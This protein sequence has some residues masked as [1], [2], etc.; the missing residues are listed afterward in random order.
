[1]EPNDEDS[2][3]GDDEGS[4]LHYGSVSSSIY[5]FRMENGRTYHAV[6]NFNLWKEWS[7]DIFV[8]STRTEKEQDRMDLVYHAILRLFDGKPFFAPVINPQRIVDMGTGTGIWALDV[9][10]QY[11]E[12]QVVGI[13]LSPI[14][15]KWVSPNVEFRIDDIESNW[16]F[17]KP[18][19]LIHSR[20]C[21][22][23]A[24][25]NWKHYL[26]ESYRCL[27][28]GG[29]VEAQEFD[30][31]PRSDDDSF[32]PDSTIL[33]WHKHFHDGMAKAGCNMRGSAQELKD[34]MEDAGFVNVGIVDTKLHMAP[35]SED[36]KFK[37]VGGFMML[38]M[39]DD[40][41]GMS[42][43]VFTRLLG[44]DPLELEVFLAHVRKEWRNKDIHGYWPMFAVYGQK[45]LDPDATS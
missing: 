18:L 34:H 12:A 27:R 43:A 6:S 13:D 23:N 32:P 8:G 4:A 11:P 31:L 16:V 33:E 2:A 35:W 15:P 19:D 17:E 3:Y 9:G 38:S 26:S 42:M 41:S 24:I 44:W 22:G 37:E 7:S 5:N 20:L 10:D 1:A 29:W 45:P 39:M 25:R 21:M 36:K 30:L 40:I 28:P 14:Q